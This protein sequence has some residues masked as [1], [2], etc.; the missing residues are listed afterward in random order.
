[1]N[2][3]IVVCGVSGSGKSTIGERLADRL[4]VP[5]C[6][7]DDLHPDANR[8]KMRAGIPLD[9]D[10]RRPWLADVG[11][12]LAEHEDGGVV[13]CSALKRSYRD[14]IRGTCPDA[15]FAQLVGDEEVIIERQRSRKQHFMPPSL[16][17]SQFAD[18]EELQPD[19][20]GLAVD[21]GP[22]PDELVAEIVKRLCG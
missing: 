21:V 16:M 3:R 10:D 5:F 20:A 8:R 6:D 2:P 11:R 7:G 17:P 14:L 15:W 19:E 9:D 1:V 18:F 13:A 4:D 12:W 22:P